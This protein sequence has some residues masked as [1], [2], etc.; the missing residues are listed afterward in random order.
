MSEANITQAIGN[1]FNYQVLHVAVVRALT[2]FTRPPT[3]IRHAQHDQLAATLHAD[4]ASGGLKAKITPNRRPGADLVILDQPGALRLMV[5]N[6]LAQGPAQWTRVSLCDPGQVAVGARAA[7][8]N[9]KLRGALANPAI[10]QRGPHEFPCKCTWSKG[11]HSKVETGWECGLAQLDFYA[12]YRNWLPPGTQPAP[13][14]DVL[15]VFLSAGPVTNGLKSKYNPLHSKDYWEVVEY[16]SFLNEFFTA[17]PSGW[18]SN[19]TFPVGAANAIE[20]LLAEMW[21]AIPWSEVFKF[22]PRVAHLLSERGY[23]AEP[24]G[25]ARS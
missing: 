4:A 16:I 12:Y 25:D 19:Q 17:V 10:I 6:K 22:S 8:Y 23:P 7:A 20:A 3:P 2:A 11:W 21:A 1:L 13:L 14:D 5:E 24:G 15:H 18:R 9:A